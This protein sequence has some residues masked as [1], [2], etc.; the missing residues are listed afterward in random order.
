MDSEKIYRDILNLAD[1]SGKPNNYTLVVPREDN[2]Y[3]LYIDL[4]CGLVDAHNGLLSIRKGLSKRLERFD[5]RTLKEISHRLKR[6][7][8]MIHH[9]TGY[10]NLAELGETIPRLCCINVL[11][12]SNPLRMK[13][14]SLGSVLSPQELAELRR[15]YFLVNQNFL[16][17]YKGDPRIH[18]SR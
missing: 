5:D 8:L 17:D 7:N 4:G 11:D 16:S 10:V 15:L 3:I 9:G 2:S 18:I 6:A 12:A 13:R 1:I 14:V